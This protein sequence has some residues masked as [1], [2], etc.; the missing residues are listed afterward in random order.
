VPAAPAPPNPPQVPPAGTGLTPP[1]GAP[2]IPGATRLTAAEQETAS[3]LLKA[4]PDLKLTESVHEGAEY[5]DQSGR[6]YDALGSPAASKFW[7]PKQFLS[8]I[9]AHL[10]KSNDFTVVDLTGFAS[11]QIAVVRNYI[12][13]LPSVSQLKIIRIGF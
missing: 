3:R 8:S 4:R 10:L 1:T 11:D 9:D 12:N 7:N 6:T 5:V 2:G 13:N